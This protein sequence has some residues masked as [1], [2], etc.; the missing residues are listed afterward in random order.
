MADGCDSTDRIAGRRADQV[1]VGALHGPG[2]DDG[3][4]L[5]GVHLVIA[6]R[7]HQQRRAVGGEDQRL[8]DRPDRYAESRGGL[9]R[10]A[11]RVAQLADRAVGAVCAQGC[12]DAFGMGMHGSGRYFTDVQPVP[13]MCCAVTL[14]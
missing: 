12:G 11:G 4:D 10:S 3:R 6:A 2:P 7:Q 8:H 5:C 1:D 9:D 14:S 13:A